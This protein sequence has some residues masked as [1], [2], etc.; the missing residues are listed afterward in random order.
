MYVSLRCVCEGWGM[1]ARFFIEN[2]RCVCEML[3]DGLR[4]VRF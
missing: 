3:I 4:R 1:Y 2:P